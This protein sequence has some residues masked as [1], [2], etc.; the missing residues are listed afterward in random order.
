MSEKVRFT[1]IFQPFRFMNPS[2]VTS[3]ILS[4]KTLN[5]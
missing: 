1:S 5:F 3:F 4:G 2:V